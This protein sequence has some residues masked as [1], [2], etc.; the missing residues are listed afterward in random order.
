MPVLDTNFLIALEQGDEDAVQWLRDHRAAEHHVPDFVA[1]EYLTGHTEADAAF[2]ALQAAFVI[3]HGDPAWIQ[4]ATRMR[5]SLRS[6]KVR[7]RTPDF[8]IAAW[9]DHLGTSVV[10]KDAAHFRPLK[11]TVESW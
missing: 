4:S 9:A 6:D 1:V 5:K 10:T 2:D 8:W 7:F 3:A 11:V